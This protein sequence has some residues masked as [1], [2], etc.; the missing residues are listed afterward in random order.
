L[1]Q[2]LVDVGFKLATIPLESLRPHGVRLLT[3]LVQL[4]GDVPDPLLAGRCAVSGRGLLGTTS[5]G[6]KAVAA[7]PSLPVSKTLWAV[8]C[9]ERSRQTRRPRVQ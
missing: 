9:Q 1:P 5:H 6:A 8:G 3:L 4:L 2:T 7:A